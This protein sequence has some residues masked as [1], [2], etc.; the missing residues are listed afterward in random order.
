MECNY[1]T[2]TI[3]YIQINLQKKYISIFDFN[4][5]S[6]DLLPN[7]IKGYMCKLKHAIVNNKAKHSLDL[8]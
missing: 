5:I 4:H 2:Q 8:Q 3:F 7:K 6:P 1:V